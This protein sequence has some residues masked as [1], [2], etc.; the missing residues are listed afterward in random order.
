MKNK[1]KNENLE[2]VSVF[3]KVIHMETSGEV[4]LPDGTFAACLK[5]QLEDSPDYGE[6]IYLE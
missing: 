1:R 6:C 5:I 2:N 3:Q 4:S